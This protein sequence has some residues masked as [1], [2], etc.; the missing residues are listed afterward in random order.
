MCDTSGVVEPMERRE[1]SFGMLVGF[2]FN[3]CRFYRLLFTRW[4]IG[5][6]LQG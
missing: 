4:V 5:P 3:F 1:K 2:I 6:D